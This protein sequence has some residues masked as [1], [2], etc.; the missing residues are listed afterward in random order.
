MEAAEMH[1][2]SDRAGI[3]LRTILPTSRIFGGPDVRFSA[4]CSEAD[5]CRPGDLFVALVDAEGDGHDMADLAIRRGAAAILAERHLPVGIPLCIVPD[6]RE[7]Y[8]TV[9][10]QLVGDPS[11]SLNTVGVTGT[12]GKT[13]TSL[14]IASILH[15]AGQRVGVTSSL[16]YSD[17]IENRAA[18]RTTPLPPEMATWLRRMSANG[19]SHAVMELSSRGLAQRR[20]A[21]IGF[22]AAIMT[23]LRRDHLDYH[24]TL[25]NYRRVKTRLF[26]ALKPGGFTVLNADDAGCQ[27]VL[28]KL[29]CPVITFGMRESAEVTA[30]LLERFSSEQ[31]FLLMA[32]NESV[33]VRTRI[34]GDAHVMNCLAATAYGLVAGIDLMTIA[35]GLEAVE[36]IPARLDRIECGQEFSLYVD[37]A[38]TPDRLAVTLRTLR[39]ITQGRVLCVYAAS[40]S[41]PDSDRPLLGRVAERAADVG[42]ITAPRFASR[43]EPNGAH[44]ILDGYERPARAHVIPSREQAIRWAIEHAEPGDALLIAGGDPGHTIVETEGDCEDVMFARQRLQGAGGRSPNSRNL[45]L[46]YA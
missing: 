36:R 12:N 13:S 2:T 1:G 4:C 37:C 44:D 9:C 19:C 34:T 35:R 20:H 27:H 31:T 40:D 7:A 8:G 42:I 33:P 46:R 32:G 18:Q 41:R 24:G 28:Q 3:S 21:G 43:L 10:Q 30:E 22:D 6:T 29:S 26:Q 16:G 45:S 11:T 23:N 5:Q 25:M 39:Q 17:S 15:T 14:L 38:D